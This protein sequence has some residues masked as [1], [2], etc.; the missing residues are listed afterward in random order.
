[1]SVDVGAVRSGASFAVTRTMVDIMQGSPA[2]LVKSYVTGEAGVLTITG[3]EWNLTNFDYAL[4][5]ASL[6]GTTQLEFG[7]LTTTKEVAL[8]LYHRRPDGATVELDIWKAR[9]GGE[10]TFPFTDDPHEFSFTFNA[11]MT[12]V[13]WA[14]ESLVAGSQL[15]KLTII[16]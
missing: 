1:V 14:G 7:G 11:L 2:T 8:R 13:N 12:S 4:G 6:T 9:S 5:G 3:I 15:F 16:S 10:L